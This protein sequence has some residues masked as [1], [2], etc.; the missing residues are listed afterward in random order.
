MNTHPIL[1]DATT[2]ALRNNLP[3][4]RTLPATE[5]RHDPV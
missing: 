2:I 5:Y 3:V 4:G 1:A